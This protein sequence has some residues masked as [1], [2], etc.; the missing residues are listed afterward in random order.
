M[1]E[2]TPRR[3]AEEPSPD[4]GKP[5]LGARLKTLLHWKNLLHPRTVAA[6]L[7]LSVLIN[8]AVLF[9]AREEHEA[10]RVEREISL[11]EF[12]FV[13]DPSEETPVARA[14]F[15]LH[16]SLLSE[17]DALTRQRL[18]VHQYR[19]Q[20]NIEELLRQAHGGDFSD[21]TLAE[22][23][24]QMQEKINDTIAVRG[25]SDV[26]ITDLRLERREGQ[27]MEPSAETAG[28]HPPIPGIDAL[29]LIDG[30]L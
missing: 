25:I 14:D 28:I 4:G 15:K 27:S 1:A 30:Q 21:P 7:G 12:F 11:G 26:I 8:M 17:V 29:D 16:L 5:T 22:L 18:E 20:Q 9:S 24:R 13:P 2:N 6:A 3:E 19:V 10:Q 23:K